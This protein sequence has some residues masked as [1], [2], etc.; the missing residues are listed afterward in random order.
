MR[1]DLVLAG[2]GLANGLIA[3]RLK[4]TRPQLS[5]ALV[6]RGDA[7]GGNHTWSFHE[8][9]LTPEAH[10]WIAPLVCHSWDSQSV[11]FPGFDR[12]FA[13][14]YRSIESS[15]FHEVLSRELG[16]ALVLD[17]EI[18]EIRPDG[19]TLTDGRQIAARAVID[20][21]GERP[22][23]HLALGFQKFVGQELKLKKPHGLAGPIIMD[24]TVPQEDGYRFVYSLP[25][26]EDVV[27]VEDTR[28]SDGPALDTAGFRKEI[29]DYAASRGWEIEDVLREEEGILPIALAGDIEK[30]WADAAPGIGLSGLRA[31]L[32]HP[33]TGYSLPDAVRLAE[34]LAQ[35]LPGPNGLTPDAVVAETRAHSVETWQSRGFFRFLNRMLFMAA[36]PHKRYRVLSRFHRL[37]QPLI[38]RFYAG[39]VPLRD[40][41]RILV[42]KPPLP[43]SRALRCFTDE[44]AFRH[45]ERMQS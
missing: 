17:A 40:Q 42:G 7:L 36:E 3:L 18:A 14:G 38:R 34:R 24:A 2:G 27:L 20:G 39:A 9:D 16:D 13:T 31:A 15:R 30:V 19:V 10:A 26:A 22:S 29:A 6:E 28:Y 21:R 23:P 41:A 1:A 8:T 45:I 5:I 32:F 44:S 12:D 4:Q 37:G 33:V 43:V 11:R 25:F 35:N